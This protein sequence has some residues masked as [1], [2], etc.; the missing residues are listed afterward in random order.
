MSSLSNF[1]LLFHDLIELIEIILTMGSFVLVWKSRKVLDNGYIFLLGV[2]LFFVGV[3]EIAHT[4]T[5]HVTVIDQSYDYNLH[6]QLYIAARYILNISLLIAP[7]LIRRKLS[8]PKIFAIYSSISVL[9]FGTIFHWKIFPDCWI[10]SSGTTNFELNS[11]YIFSQMLVVSIG[12]LFWKYSY[13]HRPVLILLGIALVSSMISEIPLT[14]YMSGNI[15]PNI[16][17]H[18]FMVISYFLMYMA[19]ASTRRLSHDRHY[20]KGVIMH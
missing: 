14:Q 1:R 18:I 3:V 13:F 12:L 20:R 19:I 8:L 9:L 7:F 15:I 16:E 4:V 17:G 11:E 6:M 5:R 10:E 2:A